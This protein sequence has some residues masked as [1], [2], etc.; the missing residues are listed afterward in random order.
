M[1]LF[2]FLLTKM[3]QIECSE[4]S[5]YKIQTPGNY[6]EENIQHTRKEHRESLK[7]GIIHLCRLSVFTIR[8][9]HNCRKL[10]LELG[11]CLILHL[12]YSGILFHLCLQSSIVF[13]SRSFLLKSVLN[14]YIYIY[15]CVC[16]T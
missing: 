13:S 1:T 5:A 6:P 14:I 9:M 12:Y 10:I 11:L 16:V 15:M 3:E 4:T 8:S 7:S 2:T